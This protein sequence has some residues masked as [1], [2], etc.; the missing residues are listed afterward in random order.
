MLKI[1]EYQGGIPPLRRDRWRH[2][3]QSLVQVGQGDAEAL[4]MQCA[5]DV[6]RLTPAL[7]ASVQ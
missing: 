1:Q 4:F 7:R 3:G 5:G 2:R 6:D